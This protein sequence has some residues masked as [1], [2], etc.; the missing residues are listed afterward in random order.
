[1]LVV[2][3][4]R[5]VA[6]ADPRIGAFDGA[7]H[8]QNVD[9]FRRLDTRHIAGTAARVKRACA[10]RLTRARDEF[11]DQSLLVEAQAARQR[12]HKPIRELFADA[13]EVLTALKPCWAMSPLLVSQLLPGDVPYFDVVVFD[14]ASQVL[15]ADAVPAL[16]R[17]RRAVVAGDDRQLP[18]TSFFTAA[19]T[20]DDE[21]TEQADLAFTS[22]FESILDTLAP[23][24]RMRMLI[25]HYR[26]HDE[27]L[28]AFSNLH[29]YDRALTTFPGI[30]GDECLEHVLVTQP[31]GVGGQEDS[32]SAEVQVVV[33]RVLEHAR[34]RPNESLGVI[35]MGIKHANR[36][37]EALR[38]A[39]TA[40]PRF[41]A[42]FDETLE[43]AFFVKNLERVQG[44]ERDAIILSVGYGKTADG[45]LLYRFG[46]L[47]QQGGQRRLNVAI[48]RAKQ[49]MTLVSSFAHT[50][51]DPDRSPAEGIRLLAGYL[52][53]AA[54]R[55]RSLGPATL[56]TPKLNPFEISVRD[57]LT[58]AEIPLVPQYGA[59][60]YR[61][62]FA[63]RHPTKPGRMVLA[64]ECDGASYHAAPTARDRDRLRQ[65]Q[66]E[67]LGWSFHRIW[68]TEWFRNQEAEVTTAVDAYRQAVAAADELDAA[69]PA[70]RVLV[71]RTTDEAGTSPGASTL[72]TVPVRGPKPPVPPG[73]PIDQYTQ[74]E[75]VAI[76]RWIESDTLLRTEDQVLAEVMRVLGFQRRGSRIVAAIQQAIAQARR[77]GQER[78]R[79][80]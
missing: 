17:A 47:L 3:H 48:T 23:L 57:A 32:S 45:R 60:G 64:I 38:R 62:D 28:I 5:Q 10:E 39:R 21:E 37:S 52:E 80:P 68:S 70:D 11:R 67:V 27:R 30:S 42:F 18:P 34:T 29:L 69:P 79:P 7:L 25:W 2:I 74:R 56:A 73:L 44:D 22:G 35:S 36:I 61:I 76:V 9:D 72:A 4:Y 14:E 8:H 6:I 13:P 15:P 40:D 66:L 31:P 16:L 43:E 24:L 75:L 55:G 33:E 41:E 26:S 65:D 63:A 20:E 1:M 58:A 51:M 54:S 12:G 59:S 53:Y 50:D 49:R 19:L 46:P 71:H 78:L 77:S